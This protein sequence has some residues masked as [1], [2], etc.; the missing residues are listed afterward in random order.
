MLRRFHCEKAVRQSG[1]KGIQIAQPGR[2]DLRCFA[3]SRRFQRPRLHREV[4]FLPRAQTAT[5]N[6]LFFTA[7][8]MTLLDPF[9]L[10]DVGF[11]LSFAATLGLILYA[12]SL[13]TVK[14]R[15]RTHLFSGGAK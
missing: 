6:T 3:G 10:G 5:L 8:A 13:P 7:I 15:G 1:Q 9:T 12:R 14:E 4:R 2:V 11:Q